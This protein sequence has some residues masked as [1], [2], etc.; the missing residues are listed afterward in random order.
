[1]EAEIKAKAKAEEK[2]RKEAEAKIIAEQKAK[3]AAEKKA[4]NAPDKTKLI[5]LAAQIESLNMPEIKGEEAQK[6]LS[7]VKT[8]LSKISV[9]IV[10]KTKNL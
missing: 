2:A 1:M 9:Y 5:E 3:E 4:K 8:L 7:D 6:I 10:E